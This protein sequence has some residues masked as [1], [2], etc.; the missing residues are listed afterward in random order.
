MLLDDFLALLVSGLTIGS[1]YAMVGVSLNIAYRPTNVFNMA[2]GELM[3]LGMLLA[4]G[5]MANWSLPCL[6]DNASFS[7]HARSPIYRWAA[8]A[9]AADCSKSTPSISSSVEKKHTATSPSGSPARSMIATWRP[10]RG[11]PTAGPLH[12]NSLPQH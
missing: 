5:L 2:Q 4:W 8:C 3:M 6:P 7:G 11:A 9:L 10:C 12:S 1:V